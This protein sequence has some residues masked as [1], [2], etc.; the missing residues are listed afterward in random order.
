M[1]A[2]PTTLPAAFADGSSLVS[3]NA[4]VPLALTLRGTSCVIDY[5]HTDHLNVPRKVKASS[6]T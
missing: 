5:I 4:L 1:A 6:N 2:E 3:V